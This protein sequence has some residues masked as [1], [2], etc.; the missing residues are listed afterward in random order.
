ML[1]GWLTFITL[2]LFQTFLL[3]N[4]KEDILKNVDNL[5]IQPPLVVI[6]SKEITGSSQMLGYRMML[7]KCR[8]LI[9]NV[10]V[11]GDSYSSNTERSPS[12][13]VPI[14][15]FFWNQTVCYF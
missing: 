9:Q 6:K 8:L 4:T 11:K 10:T 1:K 2:T 5:Q 13:M 12:L 15:L 14:W 3:L 7:L